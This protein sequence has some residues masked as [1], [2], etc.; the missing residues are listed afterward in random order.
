MQCPA[1]AAELPEDDVF[2]EDC[3]ARLSAQPPLQPPTQGPG[4]ACG[5][6]AGETDED[7]F[8]L[9]CGLRARRALPA[10]HI[11][12]PLSDTFAGVCDRGLLHDR[13]EDRLSMAQIHRPTGDAYAIVVCDGVSA[14]RQSELASGAVA[15][16]AI[17]SLTKADAALDPAT[18]LRQAIAA[19]SQRLISQESKDEPGN[20]PS[21]TVVAAVVVRGEATIAWLGDSRAYWI[22]ASG[23]K[24]LTRD[25]SW[26][27]DIAEAAGL[28]PEQAAGSPNAHAI[29]RWIGAD[30]DEAFEPSIARLPRAGPG[31]LLLCTDGLWNYAETDEAMAKVI[32]EA[33]PEGRTAL[34][35][36]RALVQFAKDRGGKDNITAAV[37]RIEPTSMELK[38]N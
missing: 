24:V 37:L 11:E 5:A 8:C 32:H 12:L 19:G 14:T 31:I 2:C 33:A 25:H 23:A 26:M 20:A 3:G 18:A 38:I 22:D 34:E 27:N 7:G 21:T 29:T 28:T 16:G 15:D 4:C 30:A 1:C 17:E 6:P 13:N 9:R 36:A 35:I 10:D